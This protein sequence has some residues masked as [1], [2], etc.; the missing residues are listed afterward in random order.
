MIVRRFQAASTREALREVRDALGADA[1]ILSNRRL[2][3]GGVELVAMTESGVEPAVLPAPF[4]PR[5][6]VEPHRR[7]AID[8]YTQ[9]SLAD[10]DDEPAVVR[11]GP[12]ARG[13]APAPWPP[14][15]VP[16]GRRVPA[17]AA[18]MSDSRGLAD[19]ALG[20]G[21]VGGLPDPARTVD[22]QA[23][24]RAPVVHGSDALDDTVPD[25]ASRPAPG[26]SAPGA[27][28]SGAPGSGTATAWPASMPAAR[29]QDAGA[30]SEIAA[31]VRS[32]R[33][34][35]EHQLAGF[36]WGERSRRSPVETEVMRRLLAAGF[37][38][39][40]AR[41]LAEAVS[42]EAAIPADAPAAVPAL[43]AGTVPAGVAGSATV[44][45]A[46]P[47]TP[48]TPGATASG[49]PAASQATPVDAAW[50]QVRAL[51]FE[52]LKGLLQP[53]DPCDQGGVFALVGPTGVGKTT[54]VA[55]LAARC[56]LARGAASAALL[57]TDGFRIGALDQLRIYGRILG[58]P[59]IAV[60]DEPELQMTL[61]D[62]ASRHLTLIDTVG[63]SQRDRRLAEQAALLS[64]EGRA[65]QRVL[66]L[67]AASSG[68]TLEDVATRYAGAGLDGCILTKIDEAV[69]LGGV[70]D[71]V[72]RHRL[73]VYF[74]TNGQRVPEDLH[75]PNPL[76]LIDRA[77]RGREA[78]NP[79][80]PASD[81]FA[82]VAASGGSGV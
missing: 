37:S 43:P 19:P 61:G 31:E 13:Q 8:A 42:R 70:L 3:S 48:A 5:A 33:S 74:V 2:P 68:S 60:R 35:V 47:A 28:E 81:E 21:A 69:S 29:A 11:R 10:D 73:R 6:E 53:V 64:G 15:Q 9:A 78:A 41:E 44:A 51:L 30:I 16:V 17:P 46:T 55:K 76:Y 25:P 54:T 1:L 66:L 34:L 59:V 22:A 23:R 18:A 26:V 20:A 67:S 7:S 80:T 27:P 36:A 49:A 62:L 12:L 45:T 65:V 14:L 4:P 58:V 38:T 77:L 52:R 72:L 63:M 82:L 79:F 56:V 50:R 39:L 32:L 71:V 40:L 57:T 24:A 75:L